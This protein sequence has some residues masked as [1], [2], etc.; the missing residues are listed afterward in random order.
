MPTFTLNKSVDISSGHTEIV[1]F[2]DT[3]ELLREGDQPFN[4]VEVS[5]GEEECPPGW[6]KM[7]LGEIVVLRDIRTKENRIVF[8]REEGRSL[9]DKVRLNAHINPKKVNG[10]RSSRHKEH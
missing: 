3:A 4:G 10:Y 6:S 7:G 9:S 5:V 2:V 8:V 1:T